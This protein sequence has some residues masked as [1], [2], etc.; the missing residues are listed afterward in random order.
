MADMQALI[1][2]MRSGRGRSD[3]GQQNIMQLLKALKS[4]GSLASAGLGIAGVGAGD[5]DEDE[6]ENPYKPKSYDPSPGIINE[7]KATPTRSAASMLSTA[8]RKPVN[9]RIT[10]TAY[11]ANILRQQ[12]MNNYLERLKAQM[13]GN[14]RR[15]Y[16]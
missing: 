7:S 2:S 3:S 13:V 15:M 12:Q 5:E 6:D 11:S 1:A 10:P 14:G 9:P 8:Q 4:M 16:G